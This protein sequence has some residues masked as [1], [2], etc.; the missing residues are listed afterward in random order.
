MGTDGSLRSAL[1]PICWLTSCL[2]RRTSWSGA[3]GKARTRF[4]DLG[5]PIWW[6]NSILAVH[7]V[8]RRDRERMDFLPRLREGHR[9]VRLSDPP[10]LE[11]AES[12]PLLHQVE[13]AH[14]PYR[15]PALQRL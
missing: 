11:L 12:K 2:L 1:S 15:L 10:G 13:L 9:F 7:V 14:S 6:V 3:V 5:A 4:P 8:V